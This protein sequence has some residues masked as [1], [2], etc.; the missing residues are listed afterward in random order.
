MTAPP[1]DQDLP[2]FF[3]GDAVARLEIPRIGLD[4]IVV[5][6]VDREDLKRGPGHYEQTSFPGQLGNAAIAGHRTTYGEPFADIDQ[7]DDGDEI[8]ATTPAGSFLYV[9]DSLQ[10][11]GPADGYVVQT[12]DESVARITL[13]SCHPRWSASQR[14]VVSGELVGTRSAPVDLPELATDP[15]DTIAGEDSTPSTTTVDDTT[16]ESPATGA[17]TLVTQTRPDRTEPV[18]TTGDDATTVLSPATPADG[19]GDGSGGDGL[20]MAR[21]PAR[22]AVGETRARRTPSPTRGSPTRVRSSMSLCGRPRW[23]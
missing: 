5:E 19:N 23:S 2:A 4:V 11:V 17:T 12:T 14:I 8:V 20:A 22:E 15:P 21:R 10:I 9:V 16:A 7:L 1:V 13:T 18:S 3:A 6:G